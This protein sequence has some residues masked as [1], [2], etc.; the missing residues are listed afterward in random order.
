MNSNKFI[1]YF[2]NNVIKNSF[3]GVATNVIQNI[4]FSAFFI[5]VAR[6]YTSEDFGYY[7]ISN[8]IYS[9]LLG[10]STLGLGNWFIRELLNST[11]RELLINKFFK[12]QIIIGVL[13]YFINIIISYSIYTNEMI[14]V[15]SI[16][17]GINLIFDNIIYVVKSIN[18][19]DLD[20]IKTYF[21]ST[22]EAV[23]K[24]L[25]SL[26][27]L[28]IPVKIELL[29]STLLII[30]I[31]ILF[32]FLRYGT[33]QKIELKKLLKIK[34]DFK[35]IKTIITSNW[36]FVIIASIA[37]INWRIGNIFI[38][39]Y[40]TLKDVGYY[41]VSFK[42]LSIAYI[43]PIV[44]ST[45]LFPVIINAV[46]E[47]KEK[48]VQIYK[49]I[50]TAYSIYGFFTFTFIYSFSDS[51]IN[52]LFGSK[53]IL[54]S[55]YCKEMFLIM[56]FFPTVYLQANL[57]VA[58]KKEKIDMLCNII[59]L[60]LNILICFIG[61]HFYKSISVVNIAIISSFVLFHIIQ[62]YVL[63]KEKITNVTQVLYFYIITIVALISYILISKSITPVIAFIMFW[64]ILFIYAIAILKKD[65][66]LL[67]LK[68]INI[69]C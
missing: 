7:I 20:Q 46:K 19:A 37:I 29:V 57:I 69:L 25:I 24:F 68:S 63:I 2:S 27:I 65:R 50:F 13:F 11:D 9:L 31:I 39:K 67:K 62:D 23:I 32:S 1:L 45:T 17:I 22:L 53:F 8:T 44:I 18:I 4:C 42:I 10:F 54:M 55:P 14:R 61:L 21:L 38:S 15:L 49:K 51:L 30:R 6:N 66:A 26:L 52:I 41:E 60:L 12:I 5:I 33:K 64:T 58:I 16:I 40:L 56:L 43:I 59:S 47:S 48:T 36:A 28:L 34:T 35:E 3:W